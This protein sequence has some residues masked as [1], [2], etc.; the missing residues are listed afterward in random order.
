MRLEIQAVYDGRHIAPVEPA[1]L[2]S[3]KADLREGQR[4]SL[5]LELWE[6]RRSRQQQGLLHELLGRCAR[7][8]GY[9][10]EALKIQ[11][12]VDLGHYVPADKVL[13][14][15][16][17]M[18]GWR[19]RFI[20]LHTVYPELHAPLTVVFL[21]SEADY[22]KPMEAEFINMVLDYAHAN[23]VDVSDIEREL[24]NDRT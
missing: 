12:K 9:T 16:L 13:S 8:T 24:N 19:G 15:E 4:L 23:E 22:T 14:G 10:L 1:L 17:A 6:E 11:C 3:Y 21:R 18:P 2:R 5:I 20:D 7:R